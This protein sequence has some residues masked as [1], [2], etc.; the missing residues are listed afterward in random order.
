M[1]TRC[2]R[3]E[4]V[5]VV[6]AEQLK[7]AH[8]SVRCGTCLETFDAI[9]HLSEGPPALEAESALDED[10]RSAGEQLSSTLDVALDVIGEPVS[11]SD[12]RAAPSTGDAAQSLD[13]PERDEKDRSEAAREPADQAQ[14]QETFA[15]DAG[16]RRLGVLA[17][18]YDVIDSSVPDVLREDMESAAVATTDRRRTIGYSLAAMAL[19]VLLAA[20]YAWFMP[21]DAARR[22]PQWRGAIETFCVRTGCTLPE[23]RDPQ[24]IRVTSRDVRVHPGYEGVLQ[25]KA[26]LVNA[27]PFRQPYPLLRF[28]L[29]NVNGQTIASR[30]FEPHEYLGRA[31]EDSARLRPQTPFQVALDLLAPEEAAVSFE[32]QFL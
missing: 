13:A 2:P 31:V 30:T 9:P 11:S 26:T 28:T 4:S 16:T 3:C 8:G 15:H 27:A 32:L 5:F 1:Y 14:E 22:Y 24:R 10:P 12:E 25:V 23:L 21:G 17:D 7:A 18:D 29:F 19:L 20:Q 6:A